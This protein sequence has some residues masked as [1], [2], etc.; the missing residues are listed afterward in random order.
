MIHSY[1]ILTYI[2]CSFTVK[3]MTNTSPHTPFSV[4]HFELNNNLKVSYWGDVITIFY[5]LSGTIYNLGVIIKERLAVK[6]INHA[7]QWNDGSS[8]LYSGHYFST[9]LLYLLEFFNDLRLNVGLG[10][11]SMWTVI[12]EAPV[13]SMRWTFN[14]YILPYFIHIISHRQYCMLKSTSQ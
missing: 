9:H 12:M 6:M 4:A 2:R 8:D 1:K 13:T 10:A 11:I 7:V 3:S 5:S 14:A